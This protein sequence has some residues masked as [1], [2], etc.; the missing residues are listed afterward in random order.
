V[1]ALRGFRLTHNPLF[2]VAG[3]WVAVE[4]NGTGPIYE[5]MPYGAWSIAPITPQ[6]T[7][8]KTPETSIK[9]PL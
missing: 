4:P 5:A 7:K 8:K 6:D 1:V 2:R 9:L 3:S